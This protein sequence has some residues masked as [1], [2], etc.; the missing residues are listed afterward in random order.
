MAS[1]VTIRPVRDDDPLDEIN[2]GCATWVSESFVRG[3]FAA[4]ADTSGGMWIAERDGVVAGYAHAVGLPVADGHRGFGYVLVHRPYRGQG[5]GRLL[6]EHVLSV[7]T[8][9]R[10]T[11]VLTVDRRG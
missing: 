10:V 6:W 2:A 8:P 5:V 9:D 7:C 1:D 4:A 3:A 11:G